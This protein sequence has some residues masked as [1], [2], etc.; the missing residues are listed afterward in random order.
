M[1]YMQTAKMTHIKLYESYVEKLVK[2]LP[3]DDTH[4]IAK[5]CTE[6]LLPGDTASKIAALP[7]QSDKASY[8]LTHVIKPALDID[9]VCDFAKLLFVMQNCNYN[10]V[11]KLSCQIEHD[12]SK[13][14]ENNTS[15]I[16]M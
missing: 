15:G 2:C 5:L 9:D 16:V 7:T 10:H 14:Q 6:K 3:M 12:I 8:F 11:Q 4:F 1:L 13:L